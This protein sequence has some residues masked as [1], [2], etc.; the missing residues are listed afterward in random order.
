MTNHLT[1]SCCSA[2]FTMLALCHVSLYLHTASTKLLMEYQMDLPQ[3]NAQKS[4]NIQ[5]LSKDSNSTGQFLFKTFCFLIFTTVPKQWNLKDVKEVDV[6][7]MGCFCFSGIRQALKHHI[8]IL[9]FLPLQ[10]WGLMMNFYYFPVLWLCIVKL[11]CNYYIWRP[12]FLSLKS[13]Y[14]TN[15]CK[16]L[17]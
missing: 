9:W 8:G 6:D 13:T 3:K 7:I 14:G 15:L 5:I 11:Y 4:S 16:T 10:D 2:N 17:V 1:G 12:H